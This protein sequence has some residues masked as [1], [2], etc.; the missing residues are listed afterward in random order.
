MRWKKVKW[1]TGDGYCAVFKWIYGNRGNNSK[2]NNNSI[3]RA[4]QI[5]T[6][7][8][9]LYMRRNISL[10]NI[11][12]SFFFLLSFF[13]SLSLCLCL[14][15]FVNLLNW[16]VALVV[17][18]FYI[19]VY[20]FTIHSFVMISLFS[21]P[22]AVQSLRVLCTVYVPSRFVLFYYYY[23]G[24]FFSPFSIWFC[25]NLICLPYELCAW[26]QVV[27][28]FV[29][30]QVCLLFFFLLCIPL[31]KRPSSVLIIFLYFQ[32]NIEYMIYVVWLCCGSWFHD[33]NNFR[34]SG[35]LIHL[36]WKIT[37]QYESNYNLKCCIFGLSRNHCARKHN[38]TIN[39]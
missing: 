34:T 35:F 15:I 25:T 30:R 23:C 6:T 20:S 39:N 13:L 26:V 8:I 18:S 29:C 3:L 12:C 38:K 22:I 19:S 36:D 21:F 37:Q 33:K 1:P 9:I 16:K 14:S 10:R 5:Q 17:R 31:S 24:I 28:Y 27:L 4:E 7:N 2:E 32:L 11:R